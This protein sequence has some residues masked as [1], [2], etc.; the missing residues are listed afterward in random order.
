MSTIQTNNTDLQA[1]LDAVQA[2]PDKVAA[3]TYETCSIDILWEIPNDNDKIIYTKL[4]DGIPIMTTISGYPM[5]SKLE[6]VVVGSMF[7]VQSGYSY[8]ITFSL[9]IS[10]PLYPLYSEGTGTTDETENHLTLYILESS[11]GLNI[12]NTTLQLYVGGTD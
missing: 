12:A 2:L 7:Y 10:P 11:T 4:V 5:P 6:D 8:W 1:I 3:P 9:D